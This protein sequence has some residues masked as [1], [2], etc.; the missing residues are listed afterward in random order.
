MLAGNQW[1]NQQL[2]C[3]RHGRRLSP[4][5]LIGR[6]AVNATLKAPARDM[7]Y[8]HFPKSSQLARRLLPISGADPRLIFPCARKE[9][10]FPKTTEVT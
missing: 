8:V 2:P 5:L 4:M 6:Q 10:Q 9:G 3:Q 7:V 1:A